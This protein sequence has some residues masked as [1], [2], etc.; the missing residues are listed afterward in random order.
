MSPCSGHSEGEK[1]EI[2]TQISN[3]T[4][5]VMCDIEGQSH[6]RLRIAVAINSGVINSVING[7]S[8]V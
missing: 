4:E 1:K 7:G 3:V 2:P 5:S 8:V 6:C